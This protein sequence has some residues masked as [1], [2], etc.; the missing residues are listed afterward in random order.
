MME[1]EPGWEDD[2]TAWY[3]TDHVPA[4]LGVP[5]SPAGAGTEP[6]KGSRVLAV[7]EIETPEIFK[8]DAYKKAEQRVDACDWS[9]IA[10]ES[11]GTCTSSPTGA[12]GRRSGCIGS[13]WRV[14]WP[15]WQVASACPMDGGIA[16][17]R[18]GSPR[19]SRSAC[20]R[21]DGGLRP[22][23][24][25][26]EP[27]APYL[28]AESSEED[29]A[30]MPGRGRALRAP[31]YYKDLISQG[32]EVAA[33]SDRGPEA[34]DRVAVSWAAGGTALPGHGGTERPDFVFSLGRHSDM[35]GIASYL[36]DRNIPFGME[37][38]MGL[39]SAKSPLWSSRPAGRVVSLPCP[40][41]FAGR[42][43]AKV[44]E[45][46]GPALDLSF[47]SFRFTTGPVSRY[48]EAG[49]EWILNRREAGGGCM[50][51]LGIHFTDLF[52]HLTH[53]RPAACGHDEQPHQP[54]RGG[55]L[56]GHHYGSGRR[57]LLPHRDRLFAP[58]SALGSSLECILR[59]LTGTTRCTRTG[60]SAPAPVTAGAHARPYRPDL[61]LWAIHT[62]MRSGPPDGRPLWRPSKITIEPSRWWR[63]PTERPGQAGRG[64]I[65]EKL[66]GMQWHRTNPP[67]KRS[68]R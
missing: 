67:K 29:N 32:I 13:R 20:Q 19:Q 30:D 61:L 49:S 55:G 42:P 59:G 47:A 9:L 56:L 36:L 63:P 7:Y 58:Q 35:A 68:G 22:W 43:G 8:G 52:M 50:L 37:K 34:A 18:T 40:L 14:R 24:Q 25:A 41:H 51:N 60:R 39:A 31:Y 23:R 66:R 5:D 65:R 45:L 3:N 11:A 4:L 57:G 64:A 54:L 15:R 62:G 6:W 28:I 38:P 16:A 2:F 48:F 10:A 1:P 46:E 17:Q 26:P 27:E 21:S 44:L 33:V 53:Q 12:N